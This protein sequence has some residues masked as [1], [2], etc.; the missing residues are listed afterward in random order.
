VVPQLSTEL[1]GRDF[2]FVHTH[3]FKV[4]VDFFQQ[5]KTIGQ[6]QGQ[7]NGDSTESKERF[8]IRQSPHV[9]A[10]HS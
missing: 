1:R 3:L 2:G 6:T 9:P 8:R 4:Q 10:E 5:K 7:T